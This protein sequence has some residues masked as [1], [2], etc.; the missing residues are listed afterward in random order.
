MYPFSRWLCFFVLWLSDMVFIV[1]TTKNEFAKPLR[2]FPSR[3]TTMYQPSLKRNFV[4]THRSK[5]KFISH[6]RVFVSASECAPAYL[7]KY[8]SVEFQRTQHFVCMPCTYIYAEEGTPA[9]PEYIRFALPHYGW[10]CGCA[11]QCE[12]V[13]FSKTVCCM[14]RA[15][16]V[17]KL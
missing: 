14:Q 17:G 12:R 4:L 10:M 8:T 3:T 9:N 2:N 6:I 13:Y 11:L 7:T 15:W 5:I 1:S 16:F